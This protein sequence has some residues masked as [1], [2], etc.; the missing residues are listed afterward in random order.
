MNDI[1]EILGNSIIAHTNMSIDVEG[2]EIVNDIFKILIKNRENIEKINGVDVKNNNGFIIDFEMIYDLKEKLSK[3]KELY[4][5]DYIYKNLDDYIEEKQVDNLGT[6][7]LIY[8][9]NTYCMLEV[10]LKSILTHN[11]IILTSKSD[12]MKETNGLIII[13]IRKILKLHKI[14]T[15]LV[16]MLYTT[17]IDTLLAN[18]MSINKAIVIG[19]KDFQEQIKNVSK[20]ETIYKG[21]DY[22][23]IYIEDITHIDFIK[24]IIAENDNIDVYV[25]KNIDVS[26]ENYI[27]VEDINEAIGQ[28][29]FNSCKYSSSIFTNNDKNATMFLR[30]VKTANISVNSSPILKIFPD[31]DINLFME[32]KNIFYSKPL[33]EADTNKKIE[34]SEIHSSIERKENN[35]ETIENFQKQ[36]K[37]QLEQKENELNNLKKQLQ[38][39]QSIAKK[40]MNICDK[41]FFTRLFGR[42]KKQDIKN[43][44]K[45]LS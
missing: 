15:N 44:T 2:K 40:Y 25:K 3:I 24:K 37:I 14:D 8:N 36:I 33:S 27:E 5:E 10:V 9:G 32:E 21:Y 7:C 6:I 22:F 18:N 31:I 45:L 19:N 26:F 35:N 16:Q 29:N 17:R 38:E 11:S 30:E 41:S 1:R 20:T 43:D 34:F 39:S 4:K 42:I 12:Y 23:D 28:I 13:L